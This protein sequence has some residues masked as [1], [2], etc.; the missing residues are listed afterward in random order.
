MCGG[1]LRTGWDNDGLRHA[2]VEGNDDVLSVA[3]SGVR[4]VKRSDDSGITAFQNP[5]DAARHAAI[6]FGRVDVD[7]DLVA[8]HGAAD[9]T[10]GDENI[11]G[12]RRTRRAGFSI[13]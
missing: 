10:G 12:F 5:Y 1:D 8:L 4:V 7:Q 6:G 3:P 11:F 2:L 13:G 9:L